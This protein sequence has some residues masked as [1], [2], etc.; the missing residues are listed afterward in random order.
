VKR[1]LLV[2][3]G[4][5]ED[6]IA[7]RIA[8][9]AA[10]ACSGRGIGASFEHFPLVGEGP[11]DAVASTVGPRRSMPSGGLVAMGNVGAL[12]RDLRS[13][14][15]RLFAQQVAYVRS[16]SRDLDLVV[17][18]G[19]VY[20]L[21]LALQAGRPAIF[22]GTAKSVYVAPYGPF[23][24][25]VLARARRIFVRDEPTARLLREQN[26][27]AEAP[28][29][30]IVD[31]AFEGAAP[32]AGRGDA[33]VLLPGSRAQAYGEA[34]R[35]AATYR[36][37]AALAPAPPGLLSVAPGLDL[38]VMTRMLAEDGWAVLAGSSPRIFEAHSGGVRLAGW[39]GPIGALLREAELVAG[40]AGTANEMAAALGLP[41]VALGLAGGREDWYRM[42]QR[43]LLGDALAIVPADPSAAAAEIAALLRDAARCA[44]MRAAGPARMG[45]PGGARAIGEAVAGALAEA[46]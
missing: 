16:R 13:G 7:R 37:L 30:V 31:L 39:R 34:V 15:G 44:R 36:A 10:D 26:V 6:A 5:G 14:L 27:P 4:H 11:P 41:V 1:V 43:K 23:E 8:Q 12:A 42:R 29:N 22:V 35:L 28:G 38:G 20:G 32:E 2:S 45:P 46:A 40:Q 17:A 18:V 3:N 24:R 19:D 33:I 25:T 21:M 9:D